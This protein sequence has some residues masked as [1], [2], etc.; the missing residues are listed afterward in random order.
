LRKLFFTVIKC[1][2]YILTL[3]CL[4]N[5][6][7]AEQNKTNSQT[8]IKDQNANVHPFPLPIT[9]KQQKKEDLQHYFPS[10][11]VKPILVGTDDYLTLVSLNTSANHKGVAI[12]IPDWQQGATNPKAINFLRKTLP[13]YGFTTMSI[14]VDSKPDSFP[15]TALKLSE[16]QQANKNIIGAYKM[17]FYALI[18]AV[19]EQAKEYPGIIIMIAQGN[20][21]A[22]LIDLLSEN[23][24]LTPNGVVLLS[25]YR[26]TNDKL[27]EQANTDFAKNLANIE[28]PV[29]DL[30][31]KYD[32]D[33]V[34]NKSPQR[35]TIVKQEMKTYYRQRQL[36]NMATGFY[37]EQEL[38]TQIHSWLRAIGW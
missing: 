34:I 36:N 27:L 32:H 20:H 18:N 17:K 25:S 21:G 13:K 31:L 4:S 9:F 6:S 10:T 38:L 30:Y 19:F 5:I 37:P 22:L 16:Q 23:T 14:Q 8:S 24:N 7:F 12:L 28:P 3:C 15:S 33:I 11:K 26:L 2:F 1:N 29:L 35:L